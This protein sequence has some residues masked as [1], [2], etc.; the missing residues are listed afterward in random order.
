MSPVLDLHQ[1]DNVRLI[2]TLKRLRDIGNTLIVVEHDEETILSADYVVDV[3]PG[4]GEH[5]GQVVATGTPAEIIA[6]ERFHHWKLSL[7]QGISF[8]A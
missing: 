8:F 6:N 3:G 1:R 5:G 7:T 4:A 2:E